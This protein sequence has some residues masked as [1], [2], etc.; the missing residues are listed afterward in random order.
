M[1]GA[2]EGG[3]SEPGRSRAGAVTIR[4]AAAGDAP[5]IAELATQLGYPSTAEQI[6]RRLEALRGAPDSAVLVAGAESGPLLGWIH[7]SANRLVESDPDAEIR[8]LVVDEAARSGGIGRR[9]VEEAESWALRRGFGRISVRSNVIR[10][11]AHRFYERLG[12]ERKKTQH[13][14]QKRLV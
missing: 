12:Y 7:V 4:P 11:R 9:L 6:A 5:E 14:F 10:D 13:K 8:G 3:A 1:R 2:T